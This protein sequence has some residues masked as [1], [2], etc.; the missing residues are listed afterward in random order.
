MSWTVDQWL[1]KKVSINWNSG[2]LPSG[3]LHSQQCKVHF[4]ASTTLPLYGFLSKEFSIPNIII[5]YSL[6]GHFWLYWSNVTIEISYFQKS[7]H[8]LKLGV[9]LGFYFHKDF[10]WSFYWTCLGSSSTSEFF[11]HKVTFVY[12]KC[13]P[14]KLHLLC[15]EVCFVKPYALLCF[16][17][18]NFPYSQLMADLCGIVKPLLVAFGGFGGQKL[19]VPLSHC[20]NL[21]ELGIK[22]Q[23]S[24][25]FV[26]A[27]PS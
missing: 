27:K 12:Q 5:G 11:P 23:F 26:F 16:L 10:F 20:F 4:L 9:F 22:T 17:V 13:H 18:L 15:G 14:Q 7:W 24:F 25:A 2:K 21:T 8:C 1:S 6:N 3:Y 19:N